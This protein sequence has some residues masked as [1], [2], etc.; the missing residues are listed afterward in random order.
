M[1]NAQNRRADDKRAPG[2]LQWSESG[3]A[4]AP[5][6]K[7]KLAFHAAT[8]SGEGYD[9]SIAAGLRAAAASAPAKLTEEDITVIWQTMPGGPACWLK[10]FGFLQFARAVEEQV[11][12]NNVSPATPAS[13]DNPST[14]GTQKPTDISQ[15]LRERAAGSMP[16]QDD[17]KLM[18]TAAEEI[19]RYYGG[20][21][22]WKKTAEKKDRDWQAERMGRVDDR[23][24]SRLAAPALNPSEVPQQALKFADDVISN[25]FDGG[26]L[27][28]AT[29][30]EMAEARGLI[31]P[32]TM[33]EPCGAVCNCMEN[34]ADFPSTCYQKTYMGA[35]RTASKGNQAATDS[36]L[37][38][39]AVKPP[40]FDKDPTNVQF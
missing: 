33:A 18:V 6:R 17:A 9:D 35:L 26:D 11:L 20:M 13:A 10:S 8:N 38:A 12:E 34:G 31:T 7:F 14:A 15:R 39:A 4:A 24:A 2:K 19:E 25:A 29:V 16:N 1:D 37:R 21:L 5:V 3:E 40:L 22:A 27:D 23:I 28:G 30:Q 36:E 32:K